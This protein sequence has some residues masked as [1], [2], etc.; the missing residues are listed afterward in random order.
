MDIKLGDIIIAEA[1]YKSKFVQTKLRPYVVISN[2]KNNQYANTILAVPLT[3]AK[4]DR[5]LPTQYKFWYNNR[6][7]IALCEQIIIF[8]KDEIKEIGGKL[9]KKQIEKIKKC[10]KVQLDLC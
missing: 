9:K 3:T 1:S 10:L 7:N 6:N 4:K 5:L 8:A 2:N